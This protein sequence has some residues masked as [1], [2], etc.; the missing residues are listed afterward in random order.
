MEDPSREAVSTVHTI[1]ACL[2]VLLCSGNASLHLIGCSAK[3]GPERVSD[4][5]IVQSCSARR[6]GNLLCQGANAI[7]FRGHDI[8][9]SGAL[10][11]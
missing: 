11:S 2:D 8:V 5:R 10:P 1:T 6:G 4:E 3:A 9:I 7:H